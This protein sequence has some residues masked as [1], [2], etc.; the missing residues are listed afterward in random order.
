MSISRAPV[1]TSEL[2]ASRQP[3]REGVYVVGPFASRVSFSSQQRRAISLIC[4]IDNDLRTAGD[5]K[6][7]KDKE[8][9]I[10]GAGIAG[11]TCA[12]TVAALGGG[13]H[14]IERASPRSGKSSAD[15]F[16]AADILSTIRGA[17][18][19]DAHP[20]L[21][22]WPHEDI[23]P[24][25]RLPFLNWYESDCQTVADQ[26]TEQF[27]GLLQ[28]EPGENR[29]TIYPGLSVIGI[30]KGATE[31]W[32]EPLYQ[33]HTDDVDEPPFA[34]FPLI[35]LALG[36]GAEKFAKGMDSPGYWE[37][38]RDVIPALRHNKPSRVANYIVSGTGDGGLIE[39]LRLTFEGLRAGGLNA[40]MASVVEDSRVRNA[41]AGVENRAH[42]FYA[43]CILHR[44]APQPDPETRESLASRLAEGYG[45][46]IKLIGGP[47]VRN[48]RAARSGLPPVKLLGFW[49]HPMELSSSPYH[50]LL[51]TLALKHKWIEYIRISN[52]EVAH[53]G[54]SVLLA[55]LDEVIEVSL[56]E[57]DVDLWAAYGPPER[58][59]YKEAFFLARHGYTS[60]LLEFFGGDSTLLEQVQKQQALYADQDA[61]SM[62]RAAAIADAYGNPNPGDVDQFYAGQFPQMKRYFFEKY[63]LALRYA[64]RMIGGERVL[65]VRGQEQELREQAVPGRIFGRKLLRVV[66]AI[67][68]FPGPG[69][70]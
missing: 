16:D 29:I 35:I 60:P 19:R 38:R 48:L 8:V 5:A 24:F 51:L 25:T 28:N 32:W 4:D 22:F 18:H 57:V 41:V 34:E 31:G 45:A 63:G 49:S 27:N 23:E 58:V 53:V 42:K 20:T 14:V 36:F 2:L 43:D 68:S 21:N 61:L 40:A 50:R 15:R 70:A 46:V 33:D 11:L 65:E 55:Y 1:L 12:A 7:L 26:I 67:D 13:A 3:F 9:C 59:R 62:E 56:A 47:V 66:D 52:V 10:V 6:G 17:S 30:S 64:D 69:A 54:G 37:A 39:A 44:T